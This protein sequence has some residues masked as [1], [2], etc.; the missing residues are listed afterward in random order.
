M[1]IDISQLIQGAF[2]LGL[3]LLLYFIKRSGER[4]EKSIDDLRE[5]QTSMRLLQQQISKIE[6]DV[7]D[8]S[9]AVAEIQILTGKQ[10]IQERNLET[11]FRLIDE[12]RQWQKD[13]HEIDDKNSQ[14]I[15]SRTHYIQN[16]L[17]IIRAHLEK[18][19]GVCFTDSWQMP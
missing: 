13:R 4:V 3:S 17:M 19:S 5:M 10:A 18:N 2:G 14:A 6:N 11:A 15:R 8:A 7:K 16:K 1:T 9:K 12:I